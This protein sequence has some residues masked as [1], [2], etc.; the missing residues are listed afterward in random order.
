MNPLWTNGQANGCVSVGLIATIVIFALGCQIPKRDFYPIG[1]YSVPSTNEYPMLRAAGFNL[2][3][4][5]ANAATLDAARAS[6]LGVL[7]T[8]GTQA[9]KKM[10]ASKAWQV[11]S[12]FDRHPALWAWYLMDEPDLHGVRPGEVLRLHRLVRQAGGR[13]PTAL[14]LFQGS[15]ALNYSGLTDILMID[16]YPVPWLPLANFPQHVRMAR[17]G[18]GPKKPL[19]AVI[20]AFSWTAFPDLLPG[21]TNLRPP[22]REELRC[23]TYCALVRRATGLFYYSYDDGKWKIR[24][25][26]ATW[27]ALRTVVSEVNERLPLFQAE[28]LWWPYDHDF[29]DLATAYN[30]TL[31]ASVTPALLRVRNGNAEI[32]RGDYILAVNTTGRTHRYRV[33]LPAPFEGQIGVVGERRVLEIEN[34]WVADQFD[35]Y[36]VHVYGPMPIPE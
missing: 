8:P 26:P 35:P 7:A 21:R 33:K 3:T 20:Q 29:G 13:K 23:M 36:A 6:G 28:H 15:E 1:I 27:E 16:R 17:L 14:V 18:L 25:H 11:V 19:I 5:S 9:G 31:E 30:E 10:D 12:G 2:I 22:T 24:D 4:G 32:A 34:N